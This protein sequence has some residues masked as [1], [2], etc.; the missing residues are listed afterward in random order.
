MSKVFDLI[1]VGTRLINTRYLKYI[2]HVKAEKGGNKLEK[3]EVTLVN[4]NSKGY[5]ELFAVYKGTKDFEDVEK[6]FNKVHNEAN[7]NIGR[8]PTQD[9]FFSV[10]K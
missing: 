2:D 4:T 3:F 5:D 6:L 7:S 8:M 1:V 10:W 9:E